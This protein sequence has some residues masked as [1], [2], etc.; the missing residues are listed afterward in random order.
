MADPVTL[1]RRLDLVADDDKEDGDGDDGGDGTLTLI[2]LVSPPD[3]SIL[4]NRQ[5][6]RASSQ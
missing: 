1:K 5:T 3:D 6:D 2:R 4:S